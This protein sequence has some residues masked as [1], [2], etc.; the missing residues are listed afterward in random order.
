MS[1]SPLSAVRGQPPSGTRTVI[2]L[3]STFALRCLTVVRSPP[4]SSYRTLRLSSTSTFSAFVVWTKGELLVVPIAVRAIVRAHWPMP[5]AFVTPSSSRPSSGR[6]LSNT[7]TPPNSEPMFPMRTQL[8][9]PLYQ[10]SPFTSIRALKGSPRRC[11]DAVQMYA[12]RPKR[13]F[14]P[15][16]ASWII[17][18]V[19]SRSRHDRESL[20]V[21]LS[22]VELALRPV[23]PDVHRLGDV[24]R[25]VEAGGEQVRRS[26]RDDRER[27]APLPARTSTHRCT[28]PS[29][30]QTKINSAPSFSAARTRLGAKRLF[31]TSDQMGSI[32]P[33]RESVSRSSSSPP[34]IVLPAWAITATLVM[35]LTSASVAARPSRRSAAAPAARAAN[36]VTTSAPDAQE[37]A[38]DAVRQMVHAAIHARPGD[39]Q[40]DRDQERA[41]RDGDDGATRARGE[42]QQQ[43]PYSASAAAV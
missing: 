25:K 41:G 37:Q 22:D 17:L 32:T 42:H 13:S 36:T 4:S 30:P 16:S 1:S 2:A 15:P 14:S 27:D 12:R 10:S 19:E 28:I 35:P 34:P 6:A 31:G 43:P 33:A 20:A 26:R 39:E 29:P 5:S 23:Q 24:L 21:D 38:G 9:L 8:A 7:S 11:F 18:R 3:G 40:G